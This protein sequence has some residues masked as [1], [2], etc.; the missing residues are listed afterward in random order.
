FRP[1]A[2]G[3]SLHAEGR[4]RDFSLF[5]P[6]SSGFSVSARN[7]IHVRARDQPAQPHTSLRPGRDPMPS[8]TIDGP[9]G[10]RFRAQQVPNNARDQQKIVNLLA[11]IPAAQGG[12]RESWQLAP[13]S[14]GGDR[15]CPKP[16]GDA[17]W[18]FQTFWKAKEKLV[19]V[20][21]VVDPGKSSL[22]K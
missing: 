18:D 21:G 14:P 5:L 20:D 6:C 7:W 13:A 1:A 16:L 3:S 2:Q 4:G 22:K 11:A 15:N 10:L 17:I 8:I 9:L 12:K 19:V